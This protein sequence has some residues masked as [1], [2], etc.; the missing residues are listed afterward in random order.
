MEKKISD[1]D[2]LAD[3]EGLLRPGLSYRITEAHEFVKTKLL[4]KI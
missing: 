4:E 3:M 1:Q 2:F